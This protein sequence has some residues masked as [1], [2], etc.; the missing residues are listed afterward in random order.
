MKKN[1]RIRRQDF[2]PI[3]QSTNLITIPNGKMSSEEDTKRPPRPKYCAED[4]SFDLKEVTFLKEYKRRYE[5]TKYMCEKVDH[6]GPG[7]Y[8]DAP[9]IGIT[10]SKKTRTYYMKPRW[11]KPGGCNCPVSSLCHQSYFDGAEF[12]DEAWSTDDE[13]GVRIYYVGGP[14]QG[15]TEVR[16]ENMKDGKRV[17]KDEVVKPYEGVVKK[18]EDVCIHGTRVEVVKRESFATLYTSDNDEHIEPYD[19]PTTA[20]KRTQKA[21]HDG[22]ARRKKKKKLATVKKELICDFCPAM[23]A[24]KPCDE[25]AREIQ[26][27]YEG[28]NAEAETEGPP[29]EQIKSDDDRDSC[30][31]CSSTP[32]VWEQT[33]DSSFL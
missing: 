3:R 17:E 31:L 8:T 33:V 27:Y 6:S 18:S 5:Q 16:V 19:L 9:V 29:W 11:V 24:G 23:D 25:E 2:L 15:S 22:K 28:I 7:S 4:P 1:K 21:V 13:E 30:E 14:N 20:A 32:C 10:T 26:D 12:E